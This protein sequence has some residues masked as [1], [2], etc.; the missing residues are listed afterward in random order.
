ME[1]KRFLNE[2]GA[3]L[4]V[5]QVRTKLEKKIDDLEAALAGQTGGA[6]ESQILVVAS[7]PAVGLANTI[8]FVVSGG[9][10]HFV[11]WIY[12]GG[13]WLSLGECDVDLSQYWSKADLDISNYWAKSELN[14]SNHWRKDELTALTNG[15]ITT[16]I[17]EV[18]GS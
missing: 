10:D 11:Q 7:L 15:E 16:L 17:T 6:T 4:L 14:P 12:S 3:R 8:Y 13:S 1:I 9:A 2:D 5:E 18:F